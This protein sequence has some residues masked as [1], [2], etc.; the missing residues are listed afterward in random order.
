MPIKK[1]DGAIGNVPPPEAPREVSQPLSPELIAQQQALAKA[2]ERELAPFN[3]PAARVPAIKPPDVPLV[4]AP[5]GPQSPALTL[6]EEVEFFDEPVAPGV[7]VDKRGDGDGAGLPSLEP[8]SEAVQFGQGAHNHQPAASNT[9]SPSR[10]MPKPVADAGKQITGGWGALQESYEPLTGAE[11]RDMALV[12]MD[13]IT[14]I[15]QNDLR[16]TLAS[17]YPRVEIAVE[18]KVNCYE[19]NQPISVRRVRPAQGSMPLDVARKL[20]DEVVFVIV[21]KRQEFNEKDES[22]TPANAMRLEI[23]SE[24]P[25]K[26]YV[27]VPGGRLLVDSVR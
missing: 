13:E 18:L 15:L 14:K 8:S 6:S 1:L 25:R 10:G 11:V 27:E 2:N 20:A 22:E 23:G 3:P 19:M 4:K 24:A 7:R 26:Q 16:F 12:L 21:N 9:D 5:R 17:T